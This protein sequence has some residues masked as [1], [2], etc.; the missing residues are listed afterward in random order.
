VIAW[1]PPSGCRLNGPE[2]GGGH[3]SDQKSI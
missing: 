1:L 2:Q 3:E